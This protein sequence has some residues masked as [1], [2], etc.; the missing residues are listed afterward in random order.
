MG[1]ALLGKLDERLSI[2]HCTD[3]L[4]GFG[5]Y[6]SHYLQLEREVIGRS[7][8]LITTSDN[9]RDTKKLYN[10]HAYSVPNAADVE[11]FKQALQPLPEP[12]DLAAIPHPRFGFIGQ[13][14][15]RFH[16][17]LVYQAA[18]ARPGWQFVVIGPVLPGYGEKP[19]LLKLP[20]VHAIG[21]RPNSSLPAYLRALDVCLIPYKLDKLTAGIYP[22][23]LHE[24][25]AA[26]KPV[27]ATR[28]PSLE[29]F[30]GTIALVD[31]SEDFVTKGE[32]AIQSAHDPAAI[33]SRVAVAERN[34]WKNRIETVVQ[35]IDQHLA[36]KEG[37]LPGPLKIKTN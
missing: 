28:L 33:A 12:P 8:L 4:T 22:L 35:L 16:T 37:Q 32:L 25:L 2:Y 23:K 24:Y 6:S 3:E 10:P 9:L 15:Y 11:H 21:P 13:F 7:D 34:S 19:P 1:A 14:E 31:S 18:L 36:E 5:T 30:E 27:L 20:N 26:G 17:E 29:A